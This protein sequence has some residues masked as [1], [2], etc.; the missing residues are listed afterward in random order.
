MKVAIYDT[1]HFETIYSLI[2]IWNTKDNEIHLFLPK[3]VEIVVRQLLKEKGENCYWITKNENNLK[4]IIQIK[5][6]IR[7][8]HIDFLILNTITYHH[9]L[10]AFLCKHLR[11]PVLLTV[12]D[13]NTTFD[14]KLQFS[15]RSFLRYAGKKALVK[16]VSGYATLLS[17]TKE[18]IQEKFVKKKPVYVFPGAVYD[19][20]QKINETDAVLRIVIPGTIERKRRDYNEVIKL[21]NL[22]KPAMPIEFTLLGGC[23]HSEAREIVNTI[24]KLGSPLI[25]I[26]TNHENFIPPEVY[27]EQLEKADFIFAPLVKVIVTNEKTKEVY[28][29][30][31]TSG[32]FFD[33]VKAGKCLLIPAHIPVPD[34]LAFQSYTYHSLEELADLLSDT[35]PTLKNELKRKALKNSELFTPE[36]IRAR[37]PFF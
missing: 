13:A 17:T 26:K 29:Y 4:Y 9:L 27:E 12:H 37:L 11:I 7:Q 21:L 22:I 35:D 14:P 10:F 28:G 25:N 36:A 19:P 31:Q 30:T 20:V 5:N 24:E 18:Y 16:H 8:N 34:E 32:S 23:R 6:Y 2:R 33:A 3:N 15:I 1:E